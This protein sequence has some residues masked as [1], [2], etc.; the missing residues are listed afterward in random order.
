MLAVAVKHGLGSVIDARVVSGIITWLARHRQ[1][2]Q[3]ELI[4]FSVNLSPNALFDEPF[5]KLVELCL[6]KA[7]LPN[8]LLA[9]EI[10]D[11]LCRDHRV[12]VGV[13][14]KAF[15][16]MG[17]AL[18]IDDF[19]LRD[20]SMDLLR[21]KGLRTLKLDP[22]LT[23]GVRGDKI[24]QATVSGTAQAARVMGMYTVAKRRVR[25]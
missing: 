6:A 2:W 17:V 8:A 14:G 13:L 21:I 10:D 20:G 3:D 23:S 19:T 7:A 5:V 25:R 15:S 24:R 9:F 11:R 22:E 16:A 12:R 18:I 1:I 4:R